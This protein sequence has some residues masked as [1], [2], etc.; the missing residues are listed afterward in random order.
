MNTPSSPVTRRSFVKSTSTAAA[1]ATLSPG[2]FGAANKRPLKSALI[3]T[4]GRGTGAAN[5]HVQAAKELGADL[6]L[7]MLGDVFEDRLDRSLA[8][9]K[10]NAGIDLSRGQC[11]LGYD[12]YKKVME[13]DVD[14]VL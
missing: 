6:R 5:D 2:V 4:G 14:I 13:A 12:G 8:A 9:L 11:V 1:L 7:V 3:G 10:S